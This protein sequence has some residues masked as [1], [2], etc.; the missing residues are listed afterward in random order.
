MEKEKDVTNVDRH[1]HGHT[2]THSEYSVNPRLEFSISDLATDNHILFSEIDCW[3][4]YKEPLCPVLLLRQHT[5]ER[6]HS[7][8]HSTQHTG[9]TNV[10][11]VVLVSVKIARIGAERAETAVGQLCWSVLVCVGQCWSAGSTFE[12]SARIKPICLPG[13]RGEC[14]PCIHKV[15]FISREGGVERTIWDKTL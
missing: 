6:Q 12:E 3:L 5:G 1:T 14:A 2:D 7:T 13:F 4:L 15:I 8:A 11:G 10:L 9:E